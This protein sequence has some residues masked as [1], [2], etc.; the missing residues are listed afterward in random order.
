MRKTSLSLAEIRKL[1]PAHFNAI[2]K[3]LE[4]QESCEIYQSALYFA[5]IMAAISNTIPRK[6]GRGKG[7]KDFLNIRQPKRP[8]S[9]T[10]QSI[11]KKHDIKLPSK[12]MRDI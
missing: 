4:F 5:N 6:S 12:E 1:T 10:I 9:E 2:F 11:A 3:E 8:N 7:A